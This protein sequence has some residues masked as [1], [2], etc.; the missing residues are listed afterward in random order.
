M[1]AALTRLTSYDSA[2]M[3][4]RCCTGGVGD[5]K[6]SQHSCGGNDRTENGDGRQ[7]RRRWLRQPLLIAENYRRQEHLAWL[8]EN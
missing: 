8:K 2:V 4:D 1:E 6:A 7:T 3:F 5:L